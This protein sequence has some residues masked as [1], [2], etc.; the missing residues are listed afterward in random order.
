MDFS[1]DNDVVDFVFMGNIGISQDIDCIINAVNRIKTVPNFQVHFVGD[2]SY[3]QRSKELVKLKGLGNIIKFHGWY[4]LQQMTKF[5]KLADACLLTLKGDT[6]IGQTIPLKLQGYMA[7]GKPVIAAINGSSREIIE[8]A[9]CGVCVDASDDLSL[10]E[11]MRDFIVNQDKYSE[12]GERGRE[13]FREN[14]TNI[15]FMTRLSEVMNKLVG[16]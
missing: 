11:A 13:Y 14:F 5:Y 1:S 2:G 7:A 16:G 15:M 9:Q 3:M 10:S 12:S 8:K 4:P 6:R